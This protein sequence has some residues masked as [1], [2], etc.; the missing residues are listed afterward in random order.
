MSYKTYIANKR[1]RFDGING[2][3]NIPYGTR[4][5]ADEKYIYF[6][7]MPLCTVTSKMPMSIFLKMMMAAVC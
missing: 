2:Y 3:V 7:G 4:L 6:N 5:T 1:A